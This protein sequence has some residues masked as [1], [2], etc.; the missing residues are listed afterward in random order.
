MRRK[1]S[2]SA[3]QIFRGALAPLSSTSES[4]KRS[5]MRDHDFVPSLS[6]VFSRTYARLPHDFLHVVNDEQRIRI[7]VRLKITFFFFTEFR[8]IAGGIVH[9]IFDPE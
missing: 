7:E 9:R 5:T 8:K 1:S 6:S 3:L 2:R 4:N